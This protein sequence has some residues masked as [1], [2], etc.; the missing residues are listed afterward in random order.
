MPAKTCGRSLASSG[1]SPPGGG[2]GWSGQ[3]QQR[4]GL[5]ITDEQLRQ[6]ADHSRTLTSSRRQLRKE[7]PPRRDGA[8]PHLRRRGSAGP[9]HHPPGAT[10]QYVVDNT[11]LL[12]MREAMEILTGYLANLIDALG[13]FALRW[14]D[15]PCLAFT[16]FQPAQ[17]TTVGKRP[18]C[19]ATNS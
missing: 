13:A 15:Q 10:S 16:H 5:G 4:L 6:M 11:D 14:K 19:G 17:L 3:E 1:S 18:R 8:H 12:L 9:A 7:V 2:Y